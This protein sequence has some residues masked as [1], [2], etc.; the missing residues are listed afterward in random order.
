VQRVQ[1]RYP[2]VRACSR[3]S[4]EEVKDALRRMKSR[5]AVGLD[6]IP[7]EI[8]KCLGEEGLE[9]LTELF[10]VIFSTIKMPNE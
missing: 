2:H 8:W 6:L 7:M 9:W 1:E 5:K 10:N 3:I 4:K